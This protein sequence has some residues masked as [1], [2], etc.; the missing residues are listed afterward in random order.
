MVVTHEL[1]HQ[2]FGNYVTMQW[3]DYV[4][5]KEAFATYFTY[6]ILAAV[7]PGIK[8]QRLNFFKSFINSDEFLA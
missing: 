3:W 1:A 2:W 5:L 6:I 7:T 4:W 8:I